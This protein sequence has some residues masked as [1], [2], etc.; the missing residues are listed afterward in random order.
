LKKF[1]ENHRGKF[2]GHRVAARFFYK[3][4]RRGSGAVAFFY[5]PSR[6]GSFF[7]LTP[8]R[9]SGS[10]LAAMD[11]SDMKIC[12]FIIISAVFSFSQSVHHDSV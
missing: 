7:F 12:L 10:S 6:R 8:R 3:P 1:F 5:K 2:I 11:I 9:G 4:S